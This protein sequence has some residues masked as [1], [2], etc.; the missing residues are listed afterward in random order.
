VLCAVGA[1]AAAVV[2]IATRAPEDQRTARAMLEALIVGLPLL[3]GIYAIRSPHT[4]RF[5]Y[6]IIGAGLAWS[7]TALGETHAS[8]PYSI[9]RVSA[10]LIFP[11]L[12]YLMLAFPDGRVHRRRDRRLFGAIA[13]LIVVLFAGS[14]LF[15]EAYPTHTPWASCGARCPPNAF[16][17]LDSEPRVM[18]AVV[19]PLREV[20]AIALLAGVTLSLAHRRRTAGPVRRP[21][22]G[23]VLAMSVASTM[24]LIAYLLVRR[25]TRD[26]SLT[27][28]LGW[29]WALSIPALACGFLVGLVRRGARLGQ[30]LGRLSAALADRLDLRGLRATLAEGLDDPRID[31]LVA[32]ERTGDWRDSEG[33]PASPSAALERGLAVT[34]IE[35]E[36]GPVAGLVHDPALEEDEELLDAVRALVLATV[37]Q[38]QLVAS[39]AS[40]LSDLEESR[41]RIAR[42]ADIE[43]SRIERDLHDG[44]QQRLIGLRIKLSLAEDLAAEDPTEGVKALHELGSDVELALDE[45]RSLAHG[46]YPSLLSDRGLKDAL[47]SVATHAALPVHLTTRGLTRHAP[48]I[49]TAVYFT[50]L[51]AAQNAIK[52]GGGATG[53]WMSVREDATLRFEV[54]DDGPGFVPPSGRFNGGLRNMRDRIEAVGG[55]LAIESAPGHGTRI[56]GAVPLS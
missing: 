42:A 22:V 7:L 25:V 20:L 12:T 43:R 53:V 3:T 27:D 13:A 32:D 33:E 1:A 41:K 39:L 38:E 50:C 6:L 40:S 10:W 23:P 2:V 29:I 34:T 16:L 35:D 54:R 18:S 26:A 28:A 14:A 31:V 5:G 4:S 37:H 55:W 8:L 48:E 19:A 46:V 49:E 44:A 45:L 51:E 9:G 24:S 21:A 36:S 52:H 11:P 30:V 17:V 47:Y 15:V 56:R